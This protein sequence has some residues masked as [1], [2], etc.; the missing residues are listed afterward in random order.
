MVQKYIL[1]YFLISGSIIHSIAGSINALALKNGC[2]VVQKPSTFFTATAN[3]A[4]INAWS[5]NALHD[6][7]ATTGWCSGAASKAPYV[8]VFEL[9]EDFIINKLV[10]NTFCQKEYVGISA[11]DIKIEFSITS[12]KTGYVSASPFLLQENK[13]NTFDIVGV[14]ARWIKLT[15]TSNYGNTQWTE[16]MEF[17]AWG[18]Y[19]TAGAKTLST[20][21]VWNS[22]FDW[23]SLNTT[24]NGKLYGCYKWSRGELY[25]NKLNRTSYAFSWKQQ[26]DGQEGWCILVLNKEGTKLN[27]IWG[28]HSDTTK[29]GCWELT[30]TQSTPYVCPNDLTASITKKE[31][32]KVPP[33]NVMIE[34]TDATTKKIVTGS[35]DLYTKT[36]YYSVLSTDGMYTADV[37]PDSFIVVK[38]ALP[39]YYPTVD[40]FFLNEKERKSLYTT[41][42]IQVSK[43]TAGNSILLNNILFSRISF[44]LLPSSIPPLNQLIAVLN[45]YPEMIIELSGHTDNVGDTKQNVLLSQQRV[46]TVKDYLV[47]NGI[48]ADRIKTVGYGEKYPIASNDG[49]LTRKFNRRVEMRIIT[50]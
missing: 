22:N 9:S 34:V 40:T 6:Q 23:V 5:V 37:K 38:T 16:L 35:I 26:D 45:Q 31:E 19:V 15:I 7:T 21:G 47:E 49:E 13:N 41:H 17:E 20:N 39:N 25:L 10:F 3:S 33:I 29:F 24:S 44:V 30:K 12:A 4:K 42:A 1:L 18:D 48:N 36:N 11:K 2:I 46:A 32:P 43:L 27:G 28:L 14:K 8:F 50:M